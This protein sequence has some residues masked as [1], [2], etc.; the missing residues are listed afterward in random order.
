MK[1]LVIYQSEMSTRNTKYSK[2][3]KLYVPK[4][5]FCVN[6]RALRYNGCIEFNKLPS[7]IQDCKTIA[8]FKCKAFKYITQSVQS[9]IDF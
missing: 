1:E 7:D 9:F 2:A 8:Y 6:R 3:N 5:N 4:Q